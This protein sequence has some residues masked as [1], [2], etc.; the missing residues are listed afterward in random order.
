M[1]RE[2][3]QVGELGALGEV[4][5]RAGAEELRAAVGWGVGRGVGDVDEVGG[6]SKVESKG[7]GA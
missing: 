7:S 5:R 3:L 4:L 2:A 1:A 6:G